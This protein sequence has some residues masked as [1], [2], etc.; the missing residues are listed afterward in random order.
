MSIQ[1]W[2]NHNICSQVLLYLKHSSPSQDDAVG[3]DLK[4]SDGLEFYLFKSQN[5]KRITRNSE[6]KAIQT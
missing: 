1:S 5:Q 4:G 3:A 2:M 6:H